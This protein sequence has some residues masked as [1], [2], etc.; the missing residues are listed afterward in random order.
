MQHPHIELDNKP[1]Y[2][3]NKTHPCWHVKFLTH[4]K[5]VISIIRSSSNDWRKIQVKAFFPVSRTLTRSVQPMPLVLTI[6]EAIVKCIPRLRNLRHGT[7][8]LDRAR[9]DC[10][11]S[12]CLYCHGLSS[13][14]MTG[15]MFGES[16]W[17]RKYRISVYNIIHNRNSIQY[18]HRYFTRTAM[19]ELNMISR[20]DT[21][22]DKNLFVIWHKSMGVWV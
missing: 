4:F 16:G 14:T 1:Q 18:W 19:A 15:M 21:I 8:H 20:I 9:H 2:H 22:C 7:R 11:V 17:V 5:S 12:W 10:T 6:F 3:E 13:S